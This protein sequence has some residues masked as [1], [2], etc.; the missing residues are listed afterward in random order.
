[1]RN[2]NVA[3][4]LIIFSVFSFLGQAQAASSSFE[5][6][7][8]RIIIQVLINGQGP[9]RMMFDTGATNILSDEVAAALNLNRYD[10][11][12]ISGGGEN[13]VYASYCD[14]QNLEISNQRLSNSRFI[15]M[16]VADMKNAIGFP[17]LDGLIGFEVFN[18][19][20]TEINFDRM[21]ISLKSFSER[22]VPVVSDQ[23]IS[24]GFQGPTPVIE[25]V[26]D[27]VAGMFLLDTGDRASATLSLPFIKNNYLREKYNPAFSTM[28]GYGLGGPMKT[29]MAFVKLLH[30]GEMDFSHTLVRLPTI[31]S[32]ALNDPAIAGTIGMGLL[33]QF[34]ILFDYSRREMILSQ[35][36]AFDQD[37]SFDRAG[38]W[39]APSAGGLQIMDVLEN[40]P[41]WNAGLRPQ[42]LILSIDGVNAEE[43][44]V[45]ALRE[46]LKDS[47]RKQI[48]VDV[49]G[50]SR[51]GTVSVFLRD[52]IG[53]GSH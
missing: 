11:F 3:L 29:A 20:L 36:S 40:G 7:D 38:M 17:H 51:T 19:F 8:N 32:K 33:R 27:G 21:E 46:Q 52:L 10:R 53:P 44:D 25:A 15:C 48:I 34:N 43:I 31:N 2:F 28:T 37:R 1:M 9:F 47:L 4:G 23:K 24:L 45:L 30:L 6:Q 22:K 12:P 14:V 16:S 13:T 41:A 35:S 18:Q 50:G 5:L 42:Q 26:L 39:I 49:R